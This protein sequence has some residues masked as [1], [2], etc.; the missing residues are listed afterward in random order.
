MK[1]ISKTQC[2][3]GQLL[4]I[5]HP[6]A[7]TNCMMRVAL[8]LPPQAVNGD[9]CSVIYW[10]S[11]LTCTEQNFM[12]KAG[13]QRLA[14]ELGIILVAPDTSPRGAVV[15]DVDSYDFGQGAGFYVNATES[16][17]QAHFQMYDYVAKELPEFLAAHYPTNGK[18]SIM[19]HSMGGHGAL[20]IGLRN[21]D[22]YHSISAFSPIVNPMDCPWGIKAF[23]GYLG[24]DP[25]Q[26][27]DY[28]ATY[29]LRQLGCELPIRIEQGLSD[30]FLVE[31]LKPDNLQQAAKE[32]DVSLQHH[33]HESYDHSYYFI[34][35][36]IEQHMLFHAAYLQP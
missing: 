18:Q 28:D 9:K 15:P 34:A 5:E 31:Q 30:E 12:Q 23:T 22:K 10:L 25:E 1:E 8:F 19:G 14:A 7:T 2:F 32:N 16:P 21:Q 27:C 24:E 33:A 29:L 6:A 13:A 3:G 35:T 4:Q 17:W 26:W 20:V 36:F 11:G